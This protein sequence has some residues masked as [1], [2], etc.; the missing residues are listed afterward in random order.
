[1]FNAIKSFMGVI[2]VVNIFSELLAP[3]KDLIG[4][5]TP[6]SA[7]DQPI[8]SLDISTDERKFLDDEIILNSPTVLNPG[9][10][11]GC[12]NNNTFP[13]IDHEGSIDTFS[14]YVDNEGISSTLTLDSNENRRQ[15]NR[16]KNN[17]T[18]NLASLDDVWCMWSCR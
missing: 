14:N 15:N 11:S 12:A 4:P 10:L 5:I 3:W 18:K 13:D 9:Y 7:Y 16:Q 6:V 2:K 8:D 17:H 1:M